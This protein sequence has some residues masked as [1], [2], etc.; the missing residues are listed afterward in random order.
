M[1]A[2]IP[3]QNGEYAI[4]DKEDYERVS[5][6]NWVLSND[7]Q[8]TLRVTARNPALR[9]NVRLN[10]FVL[11][12]DDR[13]RSIVIHKNKDKLDFRKENLEI[14]HE[15]TGFYISGARQGSKSKYKGVG[16]YERDK[17]WQAMIM[18]NGKAIY[19]GRYETEEEAARI[20]NNA[21]LK[22]FG[23][24]AFQNVLGAD[25][26]ITE[27]KINETKHRRRSM[28]HNNRYKGVSYHEKNKGF[29]AR[30][31]SNGKRINIGVYKDETVAAKA[32]DKKAY[33]LHGD[34]AI[35]NFPELIEEY[36]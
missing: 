21:A 32:Y 33:E 1:T 17:K 2:K 23:E 18:V 15:E 8:N 9:R 12:L 25:N 6:Y 3:L 13:K 16:W 19:L 7:S 5:K 31:Q 36:K 27:N 10:H 20:Y 14:T 4:V 30:I 28:S 11:K 34:K 35:L 22:H 26:R 24:H 29:R